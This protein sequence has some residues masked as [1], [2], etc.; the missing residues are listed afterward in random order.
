MSQ[1]YVISF[2]GYGFDNGIFN[3]YDEAM[4][5]GLEI[6]PG[7][8]YIAGADKFVPHTDYIGE[9]VLEIIQDDAYEECGE[10]ADEW[11]SDLT[12]DEL[13]EF[14]DRLNEVI[15]DF[16]NNHQTYQLYTIETPKLIERTD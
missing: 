12:D 15:T 13:K 10:S 9:R 11:F 4:K 6:G 2:D 3:S 5:D 1:Y 8:F 7:D 14:S 16:I